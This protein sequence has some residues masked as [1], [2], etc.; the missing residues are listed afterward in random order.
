MRITGNINK[1]ACG[2]T[3][4]SMKAENKP[5]FGTQGPHRRHRKLGKDV[6]KEEGGKVKIRMD[7]GGSDIEVSDV[8]DEDSDEELLNT[9]SG[10]HIQVKKADG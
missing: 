3:S 9:E 5:R 10:S 8:S 4:M 2:R 1:K 7:D 6:K